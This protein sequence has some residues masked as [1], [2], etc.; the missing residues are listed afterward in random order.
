MRYEY[1]PNK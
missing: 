1:I